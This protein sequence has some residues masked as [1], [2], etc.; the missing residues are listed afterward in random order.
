[1]RRFVI[2]T[3]VAVTVVLFAADR[4]AAQWPYGYGYYNPWTGGSAYRSGYT[5]PWTGGG[6]RYGSGYNP[7]TGRMYQ[8]Q[9]FYNP[10]TGIGGWSAQAYN[11]WTNQYQYR[12]DVRRGW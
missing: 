2:V 6:A 10:W 12:Y 1:M 7:Y 5:N 8:N 3:A 9:S 4:A 11:P